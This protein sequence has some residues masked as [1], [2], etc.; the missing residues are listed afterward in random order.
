MEGKS[1]MTEQEEFEFRLRFEKERGGKAPIVDNLNAQTLDPTRGIGAGQLALEGAGK[2][3]SDLVS[4]VR[5]RLARNP[6]EAAFLERKFAETDAR[7]RPL[8]DTTAGT[9]GYVGGGAAAATP[10]M[11]VPGV[12][13]FA[14]AAL[15]GGAQGAAAP[16]K[17]GESVGE[18]VA[19][20]TA[21]GLVGQGLSRGVQ[22]VLSPNVRPEVALLQKEGVTPTVGQIL[23]G[24]A[25][26]IEDKATSLPILGDAIQ[27]ARSQALD[28]L[29]RAIYKRSL[30]GVAEVPKTI[31][32]EG[33]AE[34]SD[35]LSAAYNKLLPKG[36]FTYDP[37][38]NGEISQIS[39][40]V[41]SSLPEAQAKRFDGI[42]QNQVFN[43]LTPSGIMSGE[44]YKE[45]YSQLGMFA[46]G[47]KGSQ[48]FDQRQ[49]GDAIRSVQQSMRDGFARANPAIAGE[50]KQIDEAY[51]NYARL[52]GAAAMQGARN[53]K[54][55]PTQ[56]A[57]AV[58]AGDRSV[59][60]GDYARG[61]AL[62][63]DLS[64]AAKTTLASQY[65][66]SGTAGRLG[67]N[68]GAASGMLASGAALPASMAAL[69][70]LPGGRQV[71]GALLTQ[72]PQAS[73]TL[74]EILNSMTPVAA[75]GLG[76]LAANAP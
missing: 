60:K 21:G 49:L 45:A 25:Q 76:A 37:Q 42:L 18:N 4:G 64:D 66:D 57:A 3:V 1:E 50:L 20:G 9:V 47:L 68:I 10:A 36:K 56:L 71:M 70:Y 40:M 55:D 31:G 67:L 41:K 73:R 75:S 28:E 38:V 65:P 8:M 52:R 24:A 29:N 46:R 13:T 44:S 16:I 27:N 59:G 53:G 14:G 62:M 2:A 69:P 6:R 54:V 17:P 48:D 35:A 12:N 43:K 15:M 30:N 26:K 22:R 19:M 34:V 58:K 61:R 51:A 33:V 23:G 63:Q 5:Q 11:L 32:R 74:A 39:Q 7:D 72:R